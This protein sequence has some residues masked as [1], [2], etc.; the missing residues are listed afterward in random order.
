MSLPSPAP[1]ALSYH[2]LHSPHSTQVAPGQQTLQ[3]Q[4]KKLIL[5]LQGLFCMFYTFGLPPTP[6][7]FW[8]KHPAPVLVCCCVSGWGI[9]SAPAPV[10]S[11]LGCCWPCV[12]V[13]GGARRASWLAWT[14]HSPPLSGPQTILNKPHQHHHQH[15]HA[16]ISSI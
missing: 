12:R 8:W 14:C 15:H 11:P 13:G 7:V 9:S 5:T 16:E 10:W 1:T 4:K 3:L 6:S 2:L